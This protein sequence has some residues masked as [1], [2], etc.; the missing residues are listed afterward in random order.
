MWES[1]T[2]ADRVLRG[3]RQL[4]VYTSEDSVQTVSVASTATAAQVVKAS[5]SS[6]G[7]HA[8][9]YDLIESLELGPGLPT[10]T[11]APGF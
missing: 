1:L 3:I 6:D 11:D 8:D 10:G 7:S 5:L 2:N 9:H 4:A